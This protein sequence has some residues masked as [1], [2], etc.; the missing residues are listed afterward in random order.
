MLESNPLTVPCPLSPV[1]PP[2]YTVVH[3]LNGL[4]FGGIETLCL[5]LLKH[6]PPQVRNVLVNLDSDRLDMLPLFEQIPDLEIQ[7]QSG[8]SRSRL[9]SVLQLTQRLKELR[10]Q[11]VLIYPF[12]VTH[13]MVGLAA[14]LAQV[15]SI[16]ATVQNT[17]PESRSMQRKWQ[18][19]FLLSRLLQIPAHPC[20]QAVQRSLTG[21]AS[22]PRQSRLIPNGCDIKEI[23]RR[24]AAGRSRRSASSELI[25]G[26]VARLNVIKD[27]STLIRAVA[28]LHPRFP[29]L[30]LWLIGEGEE[31]GR[32]Q[33][34]VEQLEL[35]GIVT[36]WGDRADVPELLGQMDIFAFSTTE[37]EGFG[38]ALIEAMAAGLPIVA[39]DVA[40]CRE[41]LAN[42]DVGRLVPPADSEALSL[43][44]ADWLNGE[45]G[46]TSRAYFG[47]RSY[48][49]VSTV[50]S[51]QTCSQQWYHALLSHSTTAL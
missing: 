21:V 47:Q 14:R 46:A 39:S 44:L 25:I 6:A 7:H 20:S 51:A 4:P 38:I 17:L 40:A 45:H 37:H 5:Q 41:V 35:Q 16:A 3:V 43:A 23:A 9:A 31:R 36:F 1:S 33:R 34:L 10:P 32:L 30:R 19:I 50:Y 24:A 18:V 28:R 15:P 2:L 27:Q 12:G 42:G 13:L 22:L 48:Q 26:M 29:N 11:A 49:H 8:Q